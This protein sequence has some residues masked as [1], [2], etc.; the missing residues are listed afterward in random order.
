V[1]KLLP[2]GR[3]EDF[4][5]PEEVY[6]FALTC[7][8][9]LAAVHEIHR[10]AVPARALRC[11]FFPG[12]ALF[13]YVCNSLMWEGESMQR[14]GVYWL[15]CASSRVSVD[16]ADEAVVLRACGRS[17]LPCAWDEAMCGIVVQ[18]GQLGLLK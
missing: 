11:F 16:Y 1:W 3:V 18:R 12:S 17:Q 10:G 14:D 7:S 8:S 9:S 6:V 13:D 2:L 15:V 5:D 4:L